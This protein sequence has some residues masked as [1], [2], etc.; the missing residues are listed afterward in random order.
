[1]IEHAFIAD[2]PASQLLYAAYCA[3]L[4]RWHCTKSQR[5]LAAV[6][7]AYSAWA[8]DFLG[9]EHSRPVII[10]AEKAWGAA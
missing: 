6:R 5:D 9:P 1:M 4:A 3:A 8:T 10:L 2:P 7:V